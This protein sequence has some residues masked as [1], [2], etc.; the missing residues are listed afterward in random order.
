MSLRTT[1]QSYLRWRIYGYR[2]GIPFFIPATVMCSVEK[3][4]DML[5]NIQRGDSV[6]GQGFT[7]PRGPFGAALSP[8]RGGGD[9]CDGP[10]RAVNSEISR[11]NGRGRATSSRNTSVSIFPIEISTEPVHRRCIRELPQG[12]RCHRAQQVLQKKMSGWLHAAGLT[13]AAVPVSGWCCLSANGGGRW[14]GEGAA[15]RE[16]DGVAAG[17][18]SPAGRRSPPAGVS[19]AQG[20]RKYRT[21]GSL[22]LA[23]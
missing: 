12:R 22:L 16:F 7:P 17:G 18:F 19:A 3:P 13:R 1:G 14:D 4:T 11:T 9:W 15:A 10:V 5:L 23:R 8:H 21:P 20:S 6:D 2:S